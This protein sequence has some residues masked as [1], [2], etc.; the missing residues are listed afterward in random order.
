MGGFF[1]ENLYFVVLCNKYSFTPTRSPNFR[2]DPTTGII[3]KKSD[4]SIGTL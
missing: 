4:T 1:D 3:L 2:S